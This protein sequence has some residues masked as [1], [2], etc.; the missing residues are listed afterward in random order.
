M[1]P[2]GYTTLSTT[3]TGTYTFV[4]N[5]DDGSMLYIDGVVACSSP[6][7]PTIFCVN[8]HPCSFLHSPTG[9]GP[10]P[11]LS[12]ASKAAQHVI[13]LLLWVLIGALP[14]HSTCQ[15]AFSCANSKFAFRKLFIPTFRQDVSS[16]VNAA[17]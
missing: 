1:W 10:N 17:L 4:L 5:S 9:I 16:R 13:F 8:S 14:M 6:G 11:Q 3:D 12:Q 2:A 7:E 15:Y